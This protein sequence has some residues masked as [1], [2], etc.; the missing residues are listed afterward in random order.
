M[1]NEEIRILAPGRICLF[2]E[3]QDYLRLPVIAAAIS[4]YIEIIAKET[5]NQKLTINLLDTNQIET[6][7]LNNKEVSYVYARDYLRSAYNLFVRK[8]Y[9]L[10]QG[11]DCQIHG[12]IPINAGLSSSSALIIAWITFLSYIFEANLT[13]YYVGE[14]G[15]QAEVDEFREAGG[16]MDHFTSALGGLLYI[17]TKTLYDCKSLDANLEGIVLGDSL[18]RKNTVDD[19][20]RVREQVQIGVSKLRKIMPNFDLKKTPFQE[21]EPLLSSLSPT[22]AKKIQANIINR[23]L[24]KQAK[25]L[26]SSNN[27]SPNALGVLLNA[28]H[29]QLA[30]NL[31]ISTPKI[32]K[33]VKAARNAGALGCKINGSGFGGCMF[34]YAPENSENVANAIEG[35]GGKAYI[36]SI[37]EGCKI[38]SS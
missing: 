12:T 26:L 6:I 7:E 37:S 13:P 17:N 35:A 19:L 28:H 18:E 38:I 1:N 15:Y 14:L 27:F 4:L 9:R 33:L 36:V 22:T 16:M 11:Y 32:E 29:E 25:N 34:A 2:G 31:E 3:H 10:K 21:V 24:T 5:D 20:A 23:N 30:R 8:G